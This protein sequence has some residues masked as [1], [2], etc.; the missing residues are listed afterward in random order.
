MVAVMATVCA[1]VMVRI[2]SCSKNAQFLAIL[3]AFRNAQMQNGYGAKIRV[4][5]VVRLS[6]FL[7]RLALFCIRVT[8]G[9]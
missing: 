2:L 4:G 9:G 1:G 7:G 6:F 5:S 3:H 8:P